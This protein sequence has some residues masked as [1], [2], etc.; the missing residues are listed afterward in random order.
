VDKLDDQNPSGLNAFWHLNSG[1]AAKQLSCTQ[2]GLTANEAGQRLK[3]YSN[4][5]TLGCWFYQAVYDHFRLVKFG[6]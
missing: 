6:V 1:E 5:S 2:N 3:Q 4:A